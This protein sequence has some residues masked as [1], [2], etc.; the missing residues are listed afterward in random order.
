MILIPAIDLKEGKCVRLQQGEMHRDTVFSDRP[1][2]MAD[3]WVNE[4]CKRLHIIDLDGAF[5]GKPL[6][7]E[8]V[9]EACEKHPDLP[10]QIGG[11]IRNMETIEGYVNAG[12]SWCIIGTQAVR[13]PSFVKQACKEFPGKI[14]VG[15]DAKKGM[16]A[17]EGWAETSD[18][19]AVDL[20]KEFENDGVAAI[21][22][23]DI[24]R[25][26]MMQ[27]VNILETQQLAQ[28]ISIPVIASGGMTNMDDVKAV[29]AAEKDGVM[30]AILGRSLYD[31]TIDLKTAQEFLDQ[32]K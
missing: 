9:R 7:A 3:R 17:V 4:G 29:Q 11:G 23:T 27:G 32:N 12:V 1:V 18:I 22:Y 31:G 30:G 5:A 10:I 15:L 16:V 25:D 19:S 8:I 26:G 6:N 28:A 24:A 2:E 14:I 20:G 21:V 13:D